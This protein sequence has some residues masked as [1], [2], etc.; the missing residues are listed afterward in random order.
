MCT[1]L[2]ALTLHRR[3]R[4][5]GPRLPSLPALGQAD[6]QQHGALSQFAQDNWR[7]QAISHVM[8]KSSLGAD[9]VRVGDLSTALWFSASPQDVTLFTYITLLYSSQNEGEKE[10]TMSEFGTRHGVAEVVKLREALKALYDLLEAH[11]PSW[12]TQEH[13]DK[14]EAAL[15]LVEDRRKIARTG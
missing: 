3:S 6:Q 12:Y 13:H 5:N 9:C 8:P 14:A 7:N 1:R 11:A 15:R 4:G 10:S 2:V